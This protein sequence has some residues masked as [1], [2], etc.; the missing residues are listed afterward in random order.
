M[1]V[2]KVFT[3]Q[4]N[5]DLL[6][7]F[8]ALSKKKKPV[9]SRFNDLPFRNNRDKVRKTFR[10]TLFFFGQTLTKEINCKQQQLN[11]HNHNERN[12]YVRIKMQTFVF[13]YKKYYIYVQINMKKLL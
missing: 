11:E 5:D 10:R 7:P 1:C 4:K 12:K 3:V 8:F 9:S 2:K 13:V 6:D